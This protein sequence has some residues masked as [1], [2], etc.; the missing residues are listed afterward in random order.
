MKSIPAECH[1]DRMARVQTVARETNPPYHG[2]LKAF[3]RRTGVPVRVNASFNVRG[4][5]STATATPPDCSC[6][7]STS[8]SAA[9][10]ARCTCGPSAPARS[11]TGAGAPERRRRTG[12]ALRQ[13]CG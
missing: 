8:A 7:P 13:V 9:T 3:S 2:V 12:C 6:A 11:G 4:Q 1:A 5:P 10:R